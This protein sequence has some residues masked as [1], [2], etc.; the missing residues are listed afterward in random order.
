VP[1][2]HQAQFMPEPLRM[3]PPTPPN[4]ENPLQEQRK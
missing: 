1:A 2:N 3:N 4:D